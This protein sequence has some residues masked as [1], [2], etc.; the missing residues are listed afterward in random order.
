MSTTPTPPSP[1]FTSSPSPESHQCAAE[2]QV[3]TISDPLPMFL[4][5]HSSKVSKVCTNYPTE[6]GNKWI[7]KLA[8]KL[9][10]AVGFVDW[11]GIRIL[12]S[13]C[14]DAKEWFSQLLTRAPIEL[15]VP[16]RLKI[17]YNGSKIKERRQNSYVCV[18][19]VIWKQI[20]WIIRYNW[21]I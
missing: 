14:L 9:L 18:S 3:E 15:S 19:A 11:I 20:K 16:G 17:T 4:G 13:Q 1:H 7:T 10:R 6:L 5:R 21:I 12:G 2:N 8:H